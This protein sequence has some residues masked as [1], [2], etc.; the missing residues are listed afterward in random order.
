MKKLH[1]WWLNLYCSALFRCFCKS[2]VEDEMGMAARYQQRY[3][4][5]DR[6][7]QALKKT[8]ESHK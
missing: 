6:K 4:R 8:M 3:I 2:Y 1:L 5:V 7:R